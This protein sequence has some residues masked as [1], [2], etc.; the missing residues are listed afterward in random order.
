MHLPLLLLLGH[1]AS[2]LLAQSPPDST[3]L[4]GSE[5]ERKVLLAGVE[6]SQRVSLIGVDHGQA[7]GD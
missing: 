4:F 6:L 5:V 2:I 1:S 7:A 3:S